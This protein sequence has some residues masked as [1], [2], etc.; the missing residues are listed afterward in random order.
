MTGTF[1]Q[2]LCPLSTQHAFVSPERRT[3]IGRNR[4]PEIKTR[5]SG[6]QRTRARRGEARR[7]RRRSGTKRQTRESEMRSAIPLRASKQYCYADRDVCAETTKLT[8][9]LVRLCGHFHKPRHF[10][11]QYIVP[12]RSIQLSR[13]INRLLT[14]L[15]EYSYNSGTS[16]VVQ[17]CNNT[18]NSCSIVAIFPV[19]IVVVN[20]NIKSLTQSLKGQQ[21]LRIK[22]PQNNVGNVIG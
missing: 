4:K 19:D 5:N 6:K 2:V 13:L 10:L 8:L 22:L 3:D 18:V 21:Y 17:Q 1:E 12:T 14:A 7:R 9:A 16:K 20:L 11:Q 15:Q